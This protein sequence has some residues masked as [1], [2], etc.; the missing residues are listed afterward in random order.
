MDSN[1]PRIREQKISSKRFKKELD[2]VDTKSKMNPYQSPKC[3]KG[4]VEPIIDLPDAIIVFLVI[5]IPL[6]LMG[7]IQWLS[8]T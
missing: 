3:D 8:S 7:F 4:F 2:K 6:I 1:R 5:Y